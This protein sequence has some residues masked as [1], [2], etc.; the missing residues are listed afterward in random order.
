[1]RKFDRRL[2]YHIHRRENIYKLESIETKLL[3]TV[4]SERYLFN[5]DAILVAKF[6][7]SYRNGREFIKRTMATLETC[8]A[9]ELLNEN[10]KAVIL[11]SPGADKSTMLK[12]CAISIILE[13]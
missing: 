9:A 12:H 13:K 11:G 3:I 5:S 4:L 1:M 6:D 10:K 7:T 2:K 8:T